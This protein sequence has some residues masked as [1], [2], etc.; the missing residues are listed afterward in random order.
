MVCTLGDEWRRQRSI[1]QPTFSPNKLKE[2]RPIIDKCLNELLI[3]LDQHLVDDEF[4]ITGYLKRTSMDIILTCAFGINPAANRNLSETFFQ[5]CLQ[6]FQFSFFQS[7]LTFCSILVPELDF[8]WVSFFKYVNIVRLWLFDHFPY[9]NRWIDTDPN[10]WL[11]HH[12]DNI[13]KQRCLNGVQRFDLLQSM[14]EATEIL[15]KSS[16]VNRT[17]FILLKSHLNS[18]DFS[19]I[20]SQNI[21]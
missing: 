15:S 2:M 13:I 9:M 5:R 20:R 3:K 7:I 4:D 16:S 1:I 11:L 8:M 17:Y 21:A 18:I 6:V 19:R 10:T 14:I 12:V